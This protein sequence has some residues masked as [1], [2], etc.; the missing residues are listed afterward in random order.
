MANPI[1]MISSV[2]MMFNHSFQMTQAADII[3]EAIER[4]LEQGISY[5]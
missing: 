3:E 5:Q 1:A 4:S 2:A